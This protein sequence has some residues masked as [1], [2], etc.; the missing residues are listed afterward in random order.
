[1]RGL[2]ISEFRCYINFR[3]SLRAPH[4]IGGCH[5]TSTDVDETGIFPHLLLQARIVIVAHSEDYLFV[6]ITTPQ[7]DY[8]DFQLRVP[9]QPVLASLRGSKESVMV[10]S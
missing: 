6:H 10:P 4:H 3:R 8:N 9:T 7:G 1:M 5:F 2:P